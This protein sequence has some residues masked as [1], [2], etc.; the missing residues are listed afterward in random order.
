MRKTSCE[1]NYC[2]KCKGVRLLGDEV[3]KK[4][5]VVE[6]ARRIGS[7]RVKHTG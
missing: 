5:V 6:I 3:L 4:G 7:G 1:Q 2:I